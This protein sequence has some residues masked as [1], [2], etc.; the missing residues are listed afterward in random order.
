M[1]EDKEDFNE[2]ATRFPEFVED[3]DLIDV[4]RLKFFA[5]YF[6]DGFRVRSWLQ[7]YV[8]AYFAVLIF[9]SL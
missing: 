8:R 4:T 2:V 7:C 9:L 6:L 5:N 3:V 1:S